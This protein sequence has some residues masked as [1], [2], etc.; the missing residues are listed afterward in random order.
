MIS[1]A[2]AAFT[3]IIILHTVAALAALALGSVMF[4]R[5]KGSPSHRKLG[6]AW[7]LLMLVII[8]SSFF[9]KTSGSFSWIHL[10]SAAS[11]VLL[12][13]AIRHARQRKLSAHRR[14]MVG[15]YAGSLIVAGLFTLLPS[16]LLG[17]H[18]WHA[19]GWLA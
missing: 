19:M 11:L 16:R 14:T 3:P 8:L 15:L 18:L 10:L 4:L 6:R 5:R 12:V 9:I 1:S 7:A 2:P 13:L 17:W